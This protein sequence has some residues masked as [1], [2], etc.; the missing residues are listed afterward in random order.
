MEMPQPDVRVQGNLPPPAFS[1]LLLI[2]F[3]G[4]VYQVL[5]KQTHSHGVGSALFRPWPLA[6]VLPSP[7][8][9]HPFIDK[10]SLM[11]RVAFAR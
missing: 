11:G 3:F 6:Q 10:Q 4:P 9:C 7:W 1:A 2:P 5:A 8:E